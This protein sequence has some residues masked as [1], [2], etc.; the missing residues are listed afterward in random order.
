[1]LERWRIAKAK[2]E[3]IYKGRLAS[4]GAVE[5]RRLTAAMGPAAIGKHLGIA[6]STIYWLLGSPWLPPFPHLRRNAPVD[7]PR[8]YGGN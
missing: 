3:G 7:Q 8:Q 1:M 4:I 5:I 2:S 6:R